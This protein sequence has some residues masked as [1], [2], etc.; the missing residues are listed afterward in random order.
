MIPWMLGF[1]VAGPISGKLSDR[2]GARPFATAGMLLSAAMY[3]AM[4]AFPPNFA[5]WPF[6]AVMFV[7]GI[8]MGLFASP[9]DASWPAWSPP[10][11]PGPGWPATSLAAAARWP[12]S[13]S[14]WRKPVVP[15]SSSSAAPPIP[16]CTSAAS[17]PA[18]RPGPHPRAR[19][20]IATAAATANRPTP[21]RAPGT[22][23]GR[24]WSVGPRSQ[25]ASPL[26][27]QTPP[28]PRRSRRRR[29]RADQGR[30]SHRTALP[31]LR[32]RHPHRDHLRTSAS[33]PSQQRSP[34]SKPAAPNWPP[35][36]KKN[37]SPTSAKSTS[38]S[39]AD[40]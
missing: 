8:A 24:S 37:K 28:A 17:A 33:R 23:G 40:T 38:T 10:S 5:Y 30:R 29:R 2:Y 39:S 13:S 7:S 34:P 14:V 16:T 15:T 31:R 27:G 18:A 22:A 25:P 26:R 11:S 35:C 4:M 36:S 3:A 12:P 1:G 32:S 20:P 21:D 6:A 19:D 9:N